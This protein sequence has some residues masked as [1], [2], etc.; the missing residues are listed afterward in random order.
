MTSLCSLI[1]HV[2]EWVAIGATV[3]VLARYGSRWMR[4]VL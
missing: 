4:G 3:A 2:Y 1:V